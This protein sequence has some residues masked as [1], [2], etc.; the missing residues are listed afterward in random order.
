GMTPLAREALDAHG[1]WERGVP[2]VADKPPA[3]PVEAFED[4]LG[5]I[6]ELIVSIRPEEAGPLERFAEAWDA[7]AIGPGALLPAKGRL[8]S[9]DPELGLTPRTL[10]LLA[11][12]AL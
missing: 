4:V 12:L 2:L 11:S 6:M 10:A 1:L 5:P 8:G 3:L 9:V 7:G